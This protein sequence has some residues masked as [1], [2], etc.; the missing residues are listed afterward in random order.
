[1]SK[2]QPLT[3]STDHK[4][5]VVDEVTCDSGHTYIIDPSII[6]SPTLCSSNT[7]STDEPLFLFWAH[8]DSRAE[9]VRNLGNQ[10]CHYHTLYSGVDDDIFQ[11]FPALETMCETFMGRV[12]EKKEETK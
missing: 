5:V 10:I 6:M 9:V 3:H 4:I 11:E 12:S 7:F 8:G 1:M 2:A